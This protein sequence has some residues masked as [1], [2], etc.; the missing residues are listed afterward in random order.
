[1]SAT[2][3]A[4]LKKVAPSLRIQIYEVATE[5][6]QENSFGWHNA[7]TGHAGLCEFSYTPLQSDGSVDVSKAIDIYSQFELSKFFWRYALK[8]G[9]IENRR[10]FLNSVPH[11]SFCTGRE[12]VDYLHARHRALSLHHFF[13]QME[14]TT[15][16]ERIHQWAPLLMEGRESVPV[17]ATKMD[18][19]TDVNFGA[20]ANKLIGWLANQPNCGVAT[21][22]QVVGLK[23][24]DQGWRVSVQDQV[25]SQ[26]QNTTKFVFIGAGGNALRLVQASGIP[27]GQGYAGFPIGG[28]WLVCDNPDIAKRHH[29]KVYGP[30]PAAAPSLA[31]PHLDHRIVDGQSCLLFGPFSAWTSKFLHRHGSILDLPRSMRRDNA[32][33]LLRV[34]VAN[35][36]L[37]LYLIRQGIQSMDRRFKSL[38]DMYPNAEKVDWRLI[39]AGIRV[40]SITK[41]DGQKGKVR[42]GTTIVTDAKKTLAALL[43]ASPGASVSVSLMLEVIQTCFPTIFS[44]TEGIQTLREI[45]PGYGDDFKSPACADSW[46]KIHEQVEHDLFSS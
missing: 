12:P 15:N 17:A 21:R 6:G 5:V 19:G 3:G 39:N 10:E 9:M 28:Q 38:R 30:S 23:N 29:A 13:R 41:L 42:Y 32:L 37:V 7:G 18:E 2:L 20:L 45:F 16:G 27:E 34:G 25:G 22:H 36:E 31:S 26:L 8:T 4:I 35:R 46:R 44:S 43:G 11:V 14:F 33:S 24:A 1:M 40:Q